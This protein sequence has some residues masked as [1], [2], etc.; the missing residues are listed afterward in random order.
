MAWALRNDR[1]TSGSALMLSK[2]TD[3]GKSFTTAFVNP[4][5]MGMGG[6]PIMQWSPQGGREGSLHVVYE[7]TTRPDLVG[8]RDINYRRS[9]DGG[10]DVDRPATPK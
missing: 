8:E 2:S 4:F 5:D 9:T 6:L 3:K 7:A 10:P 1:V